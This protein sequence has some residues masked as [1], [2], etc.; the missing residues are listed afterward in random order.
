MY[1]SKF[2]LK[3]FD[4]V[5]KYF[6][7]VVIKYPFKNKDEGAFWYG[8]I[9]V[10][11]WLSQLAVHTFTSDDLCTQVSMMFSNVSEA[12]MRGIWWHLARNSMYCTH[13]HILWILVSHLYTVNGVE[14]NGTFCVPPVPI[15]CMRIFFIKYIV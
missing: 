1:I 7:T 5:T 13:F 11:R 9:H 12:R 3:N 4:Q 2:G 14:K 8:F 6:K 15:T 10:V